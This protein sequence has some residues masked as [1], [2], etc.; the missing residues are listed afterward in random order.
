MIDLLAMA[1][2][3]A[4][5]ALALLDIRS[6]VRPYVV[7]LGLVLGVGW[8]ATSWLRVSE[9]A[10]AG[11]LALAAGVSIPILVSVFFVEVH[12]WHPVGIAGVLL[13]GASA[14]NA[15][16]SVRDSAMVRSS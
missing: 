14:V 3:G 7:L 4:G 12:W 6:P 2:C 1:S 13:A 9:L 10:Y 15:V 5:S 11:T 8:A 16:W